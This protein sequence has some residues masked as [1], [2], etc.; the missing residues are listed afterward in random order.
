VNRS[1]PG[2][3]LNGPVLLALPVAMLAGL[4]SFAS[5]CVLPLV[6]G[7]FGYITGLTGEDLERRQRGLLLAAAGLF[8]L[9]FSAV[10]VS[11][12]YLAG[13]VGDLFLARQ[14]ML[15]R[16]LGVLT[17]VL[18]LFFLGVIPEPRAGGGPLWRP[19]AGLLGAPL[20]GVVFGLG[21]TPC[22]GPVLAAIAGLAGSLG[23]PVRGALLASAYCLGLGLPFLLVALAYRRALG[24]M[25][26]VR[27]HRRT[28]RMIGGAM[29]IAVG[30]LLATGLWEQLLVRLQGSIAG[31]TP[32][33]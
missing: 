14:Q 22:T 1:L 25:A 10:Y 21:W 16:V 30:A 31:F 3:V 23:S 12:G 17:M 26:A 27:R 4:V 11:V 5:P 28:V 32:V 15:T 33:V 8:V 29:L 24:A 19:T 20:L 7:Y 2:L 6:P 9:G 18:G 13:A